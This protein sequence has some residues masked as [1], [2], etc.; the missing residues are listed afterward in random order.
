VVTGHSEGLRAVLERRKSFESGRSGWDEAVC[1]EHPPNELRLERL[2]TV[3]AGN[4]AVPPGSP[5]GRVVGTEEL[6]GGDDPVNLRRPAAIGAAALLSFCLLSSLL[7]VV[8]WGFFR[9]QAAVDGYFSALADRDVDDLAGWLSPEVAASV[10][11][12]DLFVEMIR[13]A[14]YQ[15]PTEVDIRGIDRQD[16]DATARVSFVV[17]EDR[18]EAEVTLRRDDES[19]LGV[20]KGWHVVGGVSSLSVAAGQQGLM[21][22]G[23][24]VPE[25]PQEQSVPSVPG[26]HVVT[27]VANPLSEMAPQRLTVL[28]GDGFET[29]IYAVP[30]LKPAAQDSVE[31]QV[32][33]YLDECAKQT[34]AAPPGCPFGLSGYQSAEGITW[35]ID[36]Y[37]T[38]QID[39]LG[40]AIAEVST[41]YDGRGQA[42][43]SGTY[44]SYYGKE[45]FTEDYSIAVTGVVT[46]TGDQ[47]SFQPGVDE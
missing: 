46:V 44:R 37:P 15:P 11:D 4:D 45:T 43:V 23:V 31:A 26:V 47:L 1:A 36:K 9:P 13:S 39:V 8:Q 24:P 28:P 32:K 29:P 17:G 30:Q 20:F 18:L 27:A 2:E 41:P 3:R 38:L 22:N 34:V 42:Q 7:G 25:S 19:T 12:N 35:T 10:R 33:E 5:A 16:D 6:F 14:D 21:I 40:P